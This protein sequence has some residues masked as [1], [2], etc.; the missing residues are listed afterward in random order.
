MGKTY[1]SLRVLTA[2]L[3]LAMAA[4]LAGGRAEAQA[5]KKAPSETPALITGS[6]L[7][8]IVSALEE[9]GF[10]VQ[11]TKDND[12]DPLIESTDDDEPFSVRFYGCSKGS[13]C[14]SIDF[15]SGWDLTDGT[16]ADVIEEWNGDRLWGRAFLDSD[17][18]PWIDFPVNLKGG[19]TVENLKDTVSWWW[20]ILNDFED[21]IGWNK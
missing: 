19:V 8:A 21:H 9:R 16:T 1:R 20:S 14:D 10:K 12:G 4:V 3:V 17:D 6:S 5:V 2:G 11:L 18:D 15:I 13:G 7:D